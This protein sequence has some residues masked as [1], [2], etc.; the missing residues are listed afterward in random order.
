MDESGAYYTDGSKS[1]RKTSIQYTNAYIWNLE[2]QSQRPYIRDSKR[3]IDVKNS[4]LDSVGNGKGGMIWENGIETY[5]LSYVKQIASPGNRCMIQGAWG[6]CTEMTQ[7]DGM[8]RQVGG[9]SGW[10]THVHPSLI[11]GNITST[12]L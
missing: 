2:R 12:I 11:D 9:D 4:L 7:R 8:G 10:V 5:I 1:E 3:H 6:W